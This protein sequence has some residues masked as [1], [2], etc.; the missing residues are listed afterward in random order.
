MTDIITNQFIPSQFPGFYL[1]EDQDFVNFIKVYYQYLEQSNNVLFHS[2]NLSNYM[3]IDKTPDD[4]IQYFRDQ[5]MVN[6]PQEIMTNPRLLMKHIQDLYRAKGTEI[7]YELLFRILFNESVAFY[8]PGHFTFKPSNNQWVQ[9][10]YIEVT[11][12]ALLSQLVGLSIQ[13][14]SGN[15]SALVEDFNIVTLN[16]KINNVLTLSNI[17]GSFAY[18][19]YILSKDLSALTLSNA[20]LVIGSL[21]AVSIDD[22]GALFNIGDIVNISGQGSTGLGRVAAIKEENGKVTFKLVDGGQGFT[23][24]AQIQVTGGDGSGATFSVGSLVDQQI[25]YINTDEINPFYNTQLDIAAEGFTLHI[26]NTSGA[27]TVAEVV[28]A[29]SN[30]IALDFAYISGS[31]LSN[32]EILSNTAL[33]I[34]GL[35]II[36][37]DN[38]N[39]V[40]LTG[41]QASLTN[42]NLVP[43]VILKGGTSG[44]LIYVNSVLPLVNYIANGTVGTAN[45]SV[46]TIINANGYFLPTSNIHGQSSGASAYLNQTVRDTIWVFPAGNGNLDSSIGSL[47]TYE[48]LIAGTIASLTKENPGELYEYSPTVNVE[49]PL[50]WQLQIPDGSGGYLGGDA[51]VVATANS[52]NGIMTAIQVIESSYGFNPGESLEIYGNGAIY[53]SGTAIVDGTGKTQGYWRNNQSFLSDTI[54]LQDSYYYQDFAYEII[55]PRMLDTYKKFITDIVHPVQ[56]LMFGR[57]AILD[58]Q[59]ASSQLIN[60]NIM[61]INETSVSTYYYLGF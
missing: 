45:S 31:S 58:T 4:F 55:A 47:L 34:G 28:N 61:Q 33:G 46:V 48:T 29:S 36:E 54:K 27:F 51:N 22:G 11:D 2:R 21:S 15:A 18:G 39:Y 23:L 17:T 20:P 57:F 42:A 59:N 43:G 38:P 6:L 41:P 1:K 9:Q 25:Y 49:E 14:S 13:S 52:T 19:D 32:N 3:D 56:M 60:T 37:I 30:G 12:S 5:Y 24:N 10:G 26:S 8:Y 40:N 7:G 35:Q 16:N 50:I 53:A 44:D